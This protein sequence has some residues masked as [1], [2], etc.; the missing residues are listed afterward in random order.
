MYRPFALLS[1]ISLPIHSVAAVNRCIT[2][3]ANPQKLQAIQ[4]VNSIIV[5]YNRKY[6]EKCDIN[7]EHYDKENDISIRKET[8]YEGL[9]FFK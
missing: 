5:M 6:M 4:L 2:V 8:A 9:Q 1:G 7:I 3:I